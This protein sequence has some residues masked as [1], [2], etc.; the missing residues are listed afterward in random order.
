MR[1][2][3][4]LAVGLALTACS[5]SSTSSPTA[6]PGHSPTKLAPSAT[7][8]R[9]IVLTSGKSDLELPPGTYLSPDGF[10]PRLQITVTGSGWRST[11]RG[12]D[13]FDLSQPDPTKDAPLVALVIVTPPETV[14]AAAFSALQALASSA[15]ATTRLSTM[16]IAG[17]DA[18]VVDVYGGQGPLVTSARNGIA[19]D[20]GAG[21]RLRVVA[22]EIA[23]ALVVATV[24]VPDRTRWHDGLEAALPLL[25]SI[26]PS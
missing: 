14:A 16:T 6:S 22:T 7:P 5:E 21:Q 2:S 1:I 17:A 4:V 25:S 12:P 26:G 10:E 20:A 19:L 8:D 3:L 23:G 13:G 24:L 11:H 18:S 15:G 9:T